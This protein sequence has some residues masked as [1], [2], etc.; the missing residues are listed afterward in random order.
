MVLVSH[1]HAFVYLKTHKT[2]STSIEAALEPLCLPPGDPDM[3]RHR[4]DARVSP[5][6]IVGVRGGPDRQ[7]EER[8]WRNHAPAW[9]VRLALGR[10]TFARYLKIAAVRNP[11]DRAVSAYCSEL[12]GPGRTALEAG[13]FED[14]ARGFRAWLATADLRRNHSKLAL[15]GFPCIDAPLVFERLGDDLARL[16]ETLKAEPAGALPTFKADRRVFPDRPFQDWFDD[17]ARRRVERANAFE[18]AAFG[19][20]FDRR[21]PTLPAPAWPAHVLLRR[22]RTPLAESGPS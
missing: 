10:R 17:A 8:V 2:A 5:H 12:D 19:Y 9:R 15:L 3:G 14:A 20:R 1:D 6:G 4:R 18:I 7:P 11:W 22:R 21:G 13:P 16:F